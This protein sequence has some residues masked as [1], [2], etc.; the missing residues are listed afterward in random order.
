MMVFLLAGPLCHLK[1]KIVE[2]RCVCIENYEGDGVKNCQRRHFLTLQKS[3]EQWYAGIPVLLRTIVVPP[4]F[5]HFCQFPK[6][7]K[8]IFAHLPKTRF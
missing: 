3:E 6:I 1:A 2:G 8:A 7:W 5:I 4:I